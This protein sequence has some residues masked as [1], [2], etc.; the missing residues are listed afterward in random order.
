MVIVRGCWGSD[1][2][3]GDLRKRPALHELHARWN[4]QLSCS[5]HATCAAVALVRGELESVRL[6]RLSP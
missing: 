2:C 6:K 5:D 3:S 1:F 4:I